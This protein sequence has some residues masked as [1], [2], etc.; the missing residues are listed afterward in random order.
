MDLE[1]EKIRESIYKLHE[2]LISKEW[3]EDRKRAYESVK[4]MQKHLESLSEEE[5]HKQ[6]MEQAEKIRKLR[7]ERMSRGEDSFSGRRFKKM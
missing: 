5:T 2:N 6:A 1:E 7:E 4:E 3:A